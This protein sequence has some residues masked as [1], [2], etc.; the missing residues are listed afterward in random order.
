MSEDN[1]PDWLRLKA[2]IARVSNKV[3][4]PVLY[5]D[6]AEIRVHHALRR[7]L[8]KPKNAGLARVL[9]TMRQERLEHRRRTREAFADLA[10]RGLIYDSGE[11]R[12]G[13]I[14]WRTVPGSEEKLKQMQEQG[15]DAEDDKAKR[16]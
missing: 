1:D 4:G 16:R 13:Q 8:A 9:E 5:E 2:L 10:A 12:K 3:G 14:V 11:R 6:G 7:Q 15:W